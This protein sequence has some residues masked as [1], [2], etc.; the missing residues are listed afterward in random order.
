[1]CEIAD[2]IGENNLFSQAKGS[3]KKKD[4]ESLRIAVSE[5]QLSLVPGEELTGTSEENQDADVGESSQMSAP[6]T[7]QQ[8]ILKPGKQFILVV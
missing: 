3:P 4:K 6:V 7:A 2:S 1:M 5:E 8:A